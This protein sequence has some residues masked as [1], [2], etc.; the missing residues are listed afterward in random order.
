MNRPYGPC[1]YLM[2]NEMNMPNIGRRFTIEPKP[3]KSTHSYSAKP[4]RL[5]AQKDKKLVD[6]RLGGASSNSPVSGIRLFPGNSFVISRKYGSGRGQLISDLASQS[7]IFTVTERGLEPEAFFRVIYRC[8][9][10]VFV[11]TVRGDEEEVPAKQISSLHKTYQFDVA[12][13]QSLIIRSRV[14]P[15]EA[16]LDVESHGLFVQHWFDVE[17]GHA[18]LQVAA[19]EIWEVIREEQL[20]SQSVQGTMPAALDESS[21]EFLSAFLKASKSYLDG[22]EFDL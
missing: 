11:Q 15:E 4:E 13:G 10:T 12:A 20:G 18:C 21:N 22:E 5:L 2:S 8:P 14:S 17:R 1:S 6:E 7:L 19:T 3:T 16:A 9:K